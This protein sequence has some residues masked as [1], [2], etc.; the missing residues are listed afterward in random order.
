[1]SD[2]LK[3]VNIF[4][5]RMPTELHEQYITDC[6]TEVMKLAETNETTNDAVTLVKYGLI[7]AFARKS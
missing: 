7:V 3:A 6:L 4:L 5:D 1:M 2:S